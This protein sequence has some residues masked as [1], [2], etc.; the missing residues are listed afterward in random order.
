MAGRDELHENAHRCIYS[1]AFGVLGNLGSGLS[2]GWF[3][4]F[5]DIYLFPFSHPVIGYTGFEY[6]D[7]SRTHHRFSNIHL[8]SRDLS[9]FF[10]L[11]IFFFSISTLKAV[12]TKIRIHREREQSSPVFI[13]PSI[14]SRSLCTVQER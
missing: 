12:M 1:I 4:D 10:R 3:L 11:H 2:F 7:S 13:H 6:K 9:S 14:N 8:S 5:W